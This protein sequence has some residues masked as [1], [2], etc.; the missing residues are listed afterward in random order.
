[1]IVLGIDIVQQDFH[2]FD[3]LRVVIMRNEEKV[4]ILPFF[5]KGDFVIGNDTDA[6]III[7]IRGLYKKLVIKTTLPSF[8][9]CPV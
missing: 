7:G 4:C 8:V 2:S 6:V 9:I 5:R 1:M 3:K